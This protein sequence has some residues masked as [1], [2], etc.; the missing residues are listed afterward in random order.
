V[1]FPASVT[2]PIVPIV[3]FITTVPPLV[4]KLWPALSFN[5]TVIRVV[6]LPFAVIDEEAAVTVEVVTEPAPML[7]VTLPIPV[8]AIPLIVPL[9]LAVPTVVDEVKIEVYVPSPTFITLLKVPEVVSKTTEPALDVKLLLKASLSCRVIK[10]VLLPSAAIDIGEAENI[11]LTSDTA[12]GAKVTL[13]VCIIEFP[14]KV[15]LMILD[16]ATVDEVNVAV[17]MPSP[18]SVTAVNVPDEA[19][20][21]TVSPLPVR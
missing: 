18:T 20:N 2:L 14:F 3:E 6:L 1:P 11:E 19:V 16:P 13:A 12:P 8:I 5:S 15:P 9:M 21:V 17:Y 10:E 4:N 7:K